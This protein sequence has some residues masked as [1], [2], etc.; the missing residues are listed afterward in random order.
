MLSLDV[1]I[2]GNL[3]ILLINIGFYFIIVG[4]LV[5]VLNLMFINNNRIIFNV[6]LIG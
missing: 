5:F 4:Y 6:W 1:F 2:L 3:F